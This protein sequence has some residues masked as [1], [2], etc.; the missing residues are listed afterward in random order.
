MGKRSS[1]KKNASMLDT[2]DTDSMSSS[3]SSLRS[4]N[5]VVSGVD[6]VQVD[7][8]TF[9]DECLDALYEKRGSTREKALASIIEDFNSNLQHEFVEKKFATLLHQCLNSIKK[10]SAKEIALASHAIGLLALTT[11]PGEKAQEILEES[12]SPISEALRTRLETSKISALI[13]CLAVI[14]FVGGEEPEETEKSMQIMW[15]VAHPKLG[16]NVASAKPS[17]AM[18]A[19]VVSAWSFLLTTVDARALNPKS[20]QESISYFSTLLDKDDRP[21]RMAAGETLALIFEMGSLEKFC[22]ETKFSGE[23]PIDEGVDQRKLM[24]IHG[25]KNKVLNQVRG[26]SSEAGGK[27]SAKKDLNSQRNTFRDILD[28]LEEGYT[29]ETSIKIGAESLNTS[30]WAQLI[31]LNFLKHFLGGGFVKHMQENQFLHDVFGFMP[32]KKFLS[33]AERMSVG[34]KRMYKSPNSALNKA[35]TQ[36]LNKQ[37]MLS[38]DKNSGHYA[39]GFTDA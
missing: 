30:T 24:N 22:G 1:S 31:Q 13:E 2:D 4:D 8:E 3:S 35:R 28:F 21:L 16:P 11:G 27:G 23:H 29:P 10:G 20:W 12:I 33:G 15:Q 38:Q 19:M 17:P 14:T 9:L 5:M 32:K 7:K 25:L 36:L 39:V 18:I 6:E 34:E 26:L 37:R